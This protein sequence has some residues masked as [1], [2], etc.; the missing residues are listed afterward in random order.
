MRVHMRQVAS[1][2][3]GR[4]RELFIPMSHVAL[5]RAGLA[6]ARTTT[7]N[8][9]LMVQRPRG[10]SFSRCQIA[11]EANALS[12]KMAIRVF[13][14]PAPKGKCLMTGI[15]PRMRRCTM[16]CYLMSRSQSTGATT[17]LVCWGTVPKMEPRMTMALLQKRRMK[18]LLSGRGTRLTPH[19]AEMTTLPKRRRRNP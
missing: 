14:G 6:R 16:T 4:A 15:T 9:N 11:P 19:R 5:S 1:S 2:R 18:I 12:F 13:W 7:G 17:F 3:A 10:S 8:S